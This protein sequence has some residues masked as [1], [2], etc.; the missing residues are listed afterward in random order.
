VIFIDKFNIS[1]IEMMI[2]NKPVQ[3]MVSWAGIL[4]A[5]SR[6]RRNIFT[7]MVEGWPR[8]ENPPKES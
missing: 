1:G 3:E 6:Q 5:R 8:L 2:L 4:V 7:F